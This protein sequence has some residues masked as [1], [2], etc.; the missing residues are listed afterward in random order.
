MHIQK[1]IKLRLNAIN[2]ISGFLKPQIFDS[3]YFN[4]I[5]LKYFIIILYELHSTVFPGFRAF[6]LISFIHMK[7]YKDKYNTMKALYKA[8]LL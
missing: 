6:F 1:K 5:L 8:K 2:H 7:L 4:N 3:C